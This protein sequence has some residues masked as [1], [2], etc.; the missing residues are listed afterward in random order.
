M[1]TPYTDSAANYAPVDRLA[2]LRALAVHP[3][4]LL[5]CERVSEKLA[6]EIEA[7]V[8]DVETADFEARILRETRKRIAESFAPERIVAGLIAT[9]E[10]DAEAEKN[11]R[12]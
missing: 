3:A 7:K 4:F 12:G 5:Y 2:L 10:N 9:A 8:W 6:K 11:A 1:T